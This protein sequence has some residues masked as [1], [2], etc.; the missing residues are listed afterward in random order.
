MYVDKHEMCIRDSHGSAQQ[1]FVFINSAGFYTGH[2]V[3]VAEIINNVF[4]IQL[5]SAGH[6]CPLIQ[7][8]QLFALSAVDAAANYFIIK[9]FFQPWDNCG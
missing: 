9:D 3:I 4:N 5:G 7:A 8:V 2:N 6:F 1:I